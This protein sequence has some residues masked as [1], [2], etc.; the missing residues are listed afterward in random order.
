ME[1]RIA[2]SISILI[3]WLLI[4]FYLCLGKARAEVYP[5]DI[6][7]DSLGWH[8]TPCPL[9]GVSGDTWRFTNS[10][11]DTIFLFLIYCVGKQSNNFPTL[12]PGDSLDHQIGLWEWVVEVGSPHYGRVARCGRIAKP[13]C[14]P[15]LT[16]WG[17]IAL[18]GLLIATTVF[19]LSKRKKL[20]T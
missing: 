19:I 4:L 8:I 9:P 13:A 15:T 3:L 12:A 11:S 2:K 18:I 7:H 16:Q 1:N 10:S 5:V 20:I 6:T 14:G 17:T